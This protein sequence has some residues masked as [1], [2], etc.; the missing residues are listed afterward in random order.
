MLGFIAY[1]LYLR[2]KLFMKKTYRSLL[3]LPLFIFAMINVQAQDTGKLRIIM[4][5]AHPDDCDQDGGGTAILFAK[6]GY[7]VKF[8]SVTNGDAG[9]QTMKGTCAGETT[10]SRGTGSGKA[11]WRAV[12]CA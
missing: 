10:I 1:K 6:M 8:V 5:G 9:H 4:L 3:L 11:L 2:Q 7:A 12:R